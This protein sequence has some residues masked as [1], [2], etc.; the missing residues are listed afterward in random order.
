MKLKLSLLAIVVMLQSVYHSFAQ[1]NSFPTTGSVGIGTLSPGEKLT[2]LTASGVS[3]I[4][5]T[6]GTVKV[7]TFISS[8][9]GYLGTVSNHP[10]Y[11]RTNN[12]AAQVTLLQNGNFGVGTTLPDARFTVFSGSGMIGFQHTN[13]TVKFG[14]TLSSGAAFFGTIS[15]HP[16]YLRTNNTGAQI[17]LL[18]NGRVGIGTI[19][20]V[21]KLEVWGGDA[22]VQS[23]RAGLGA[24]NDTSN[25]CF[26][27]NSLFNNAPLMEAGMG[28]Y[29]T[30]IGSNTLQ[31]NDGGT[32]NTAVGANVLRVNTTGA[33][34]T[35]MGE[36][37]LGENTDGAYNTAMGGFALGR[38]TSGWFNVA[39]GNGALTLNS[40]G[41]GNT[42]VGE[43]ALDGNTTGE[44][45]CGFGNQALMFSYTGN[46]NTA[47]GANADLAGG[48]NFSNCT[49]L[50]ANAKG[51]ASNQVRVGDNGVLSIG[52]YADWT[53]I[54]DGRVKKNIRKNVPGLSFINVLNPVTY[55]LN[56]QEGEKI[57]D[58]NKL[59]PNNKKDV[60]SKEQLAAAKLEKE[61]IVYTGFIAQEV[62]KA[63]KSLNYDFSGL[64]APKNEHDLYGLRYGQF[65]VPLVKSVQELSKLNDEKDAKINALL[66][67]DDDLQKQIEELRS[68]ITGI[69]TITGAIQTEKITS[70]SIEQ[71]TPNPFNNSTTIGYSVPMRFVS[72]KI[73]VTDKAG[74]TIKDVNV[75]GNGKGNIKINTSAM[76]AGT[77]QYSL[78]VNDNLIDTKQMILSK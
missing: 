26:G 45:N 28:V 42:A 54:S 32:G 35:A 73:V 9:G 59:N 66:K 47:V 25:T 39:I 17:T 31:A 21:G 49:L 40:S 23:I 2:V 69:K 62:E 11:L 1:T 34:N 5:Q 15:N 74:K 70:A 76:N 78:F 60:K 44:Q 71:N 41:V 10:L 50:G 67:Q 27:R 61:K 3:G 58:V 14:T 13:G 7:G 46:R 18:Q 65:V 33:E 6:N 38:N 24:G 4:T 22:Y 55:N 16:L 29:N 56:L 20:P 52:G 64:D 53:N 8:A 63:A 12:G 36:F 75:K 48:T 37:A 77:Y 51:T 19:T 57:T 72:A 43:N 68:L 30:A